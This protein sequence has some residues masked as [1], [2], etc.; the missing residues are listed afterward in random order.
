MPGRPRRC[1][2]PATC[3]RLG[4][5]VLVVVTPTL[6]AAKVAQSELGSRSGSAAWLAFQHGYRWD[7]HGAW[8]RL[9]PGQA[10][11]HTGGVYRGPAPAAVLR[12]GD[13]LLVDEAGMLDQD[14]ARALMTVADEHHVRLALMGDRHQLSAVGRGG[15]LDLAARW[16][17]P[18]AHLTLETVHRFTHETM[19]PDGQLEIVEPDTDYA[20]V[21]LALRSGEQPEQT[22]QALLDRGQIRLH[23]SDADRVAAL[24]D[25]AAADPHGDTVVVADTKEQ[26]RQL[27][28][29]I[30]AR[31]VAA[32]PGRRPA[33]RRH[34]CRGTGRGRGPGGD[35]TQRPRP[36]GRQPRHLD[37]RRDRRRRVA[38]RDRR[39]DGHLDPLG[40]L[41]AGHLDHLSEQRSP[42]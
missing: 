23:A 38:R 7:T 36:A 29:A 42:R 5:V 24:A 37:R 18:E 16:V 31:H 1:P 30:R 6:K 41:P 40:C 25:A 20:R 27:N 19:T 34:R 14:T 9:Q 10:D 32:G 33:H 12:P 4:T 28:S 15:V 22:F 17:D 13:L 21:S 26:V 11:P 35:P 8:T 3:S 2:R 39:P